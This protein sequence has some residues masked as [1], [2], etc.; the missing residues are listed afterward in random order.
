MLKKG[1]TLLL[2]LQ[3]LMLP[4]GARA[5]LPGDTDGSGTVSI[6]EV[7]TVINAHLGLIKD[8]SIPTVFTK[9]YLAGK[10]FY[11]VW[12]GDGDGPTG[13]PLFEVPV[14]IKVV[15]GADGTAQYTGLLNGGTGSATYDVTAGGLLYTD[16]DVTAGNIIVNGSTADYIKTNYTINGNFDNV[17]LY[18]FDQAKALAFASTLTA[19]I[20]Q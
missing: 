14:C 7:Q 3:F 10:T 9:Q 6:S 19:S 18:F 4:V 16:T 8:T 1:V 17:D 2:G 20:P 15:Y 13:G 12:F 5:A 11:I